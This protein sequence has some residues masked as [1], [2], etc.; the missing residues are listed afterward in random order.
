MDAKDWISIVAIALS[1][2][3]AVWI[4]KKLD[5]RK[6]KRDRKLW[7]FE[8]L[9]TSRASVIAEERVRAMNMIDIYF[10]DDSQVLREWK[11]HL[12]ILGKDSKSM[13]ET[14]WSQK[15]DESFYRMLE[16]MARNLG[17]NFDPVTLQN[18]S[19]F[20]KGHSEL[21]S[22]Q[23][24]YRKA[25]VELLENERFISV[26]S[27]TDDKDALELHGNIQKLLFDLLDGNR[28]IK[29]TQESKE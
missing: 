7:L 19:Y 22:D 12:D 9:M 20:P 15:V 28:S 23:R 4:G 13:G 24:R 6:E 18:T 3:I 11:L 14:L 2:I 17:Y 25:I 16:V 27:V 1:P 26:K 10:Y 29:V 21:E 8:T 5:N